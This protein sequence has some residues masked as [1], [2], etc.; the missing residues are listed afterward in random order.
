MATAANLPPARM[1]DFELPPSDKQITENRKE[2]TWD[3]NMKST[4]TLGSVVKVLKE[5]FDMFKKSDPNF[6]IVSFIDPTVVIKSASDYDKHAANFKTVFPAEIM[7]AKAF[8]GS[9]V[10]CIDDAD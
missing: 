5:T 8:L 10:R 6:I 9:N 3:A 4:R 7:G 2:V 1:G